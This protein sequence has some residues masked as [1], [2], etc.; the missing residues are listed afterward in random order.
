MHLHLGGDGAVVLI[1][2]LLGG[3]WP[4]MAVCHCA[5][6]APALVSSEEK[7]KEY[8]L[9]AKGLWEM[10]QNAHNLLG[11]PQEVD[12]LVGSVVDCLSVD[13]DGSGNS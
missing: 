9:Q 10:W 8:F 13:F 2:A 12:V 7:S 11:K 5:L 1:F 4:R 6:G 3:I